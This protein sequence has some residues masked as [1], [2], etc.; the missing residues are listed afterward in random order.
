[1]RAYSL[2]G[3]DGNAYSLMG[4]TANAMKHGGFDKEEIDK[5]YS[6][7]TS[8]DYNHLICVCSECIDKVNKKLGLTEGEDDGEDE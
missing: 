3:V 2:V 7:A 1:M 6:D 8:G 4:Y 5:M